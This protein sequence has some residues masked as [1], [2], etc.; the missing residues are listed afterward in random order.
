MY[1]VDQCGEWIDQVIIEAGDGVVAPKAGG[2]DAD[3]LRDDEPDSAAGPRA[4]VGDMSCG[5]FAVTGVVGGVGGEH[6]PVSQGESAGMERRQ[7]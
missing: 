3:T 4:M 2:V 7:E 6:D 1:G 5:W